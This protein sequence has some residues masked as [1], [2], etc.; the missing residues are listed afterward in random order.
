MLLVENSST[1]QKQPAANESVTV[2]RGLQ[3]TGRKGLGSDK[4]R[5]DQAWG[6]KRESE[7]LVRENEISEK[8][9]NSI[10]FNSVQVFLLHEITHI[11][12]PL[13]HVSR[14][15]TVNIISFL[16]NNLWWI[17]LD[18]WAS[19]SCTLYPMN[20]FAYCTFDVTFLNVLA[21]SSFIHKQPLPWMHI[22]SHS[23]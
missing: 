20:C 18:V 16:W 5:G 22:W 23:M 14:V 21:C 6:W 1:Q 15:K 7:K 17:H 11:E 4:Q 2:I 9:G 19:S 10:S 3:N 8:H 12:K 13:K